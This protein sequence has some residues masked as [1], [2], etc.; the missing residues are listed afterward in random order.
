MRY[1]PGMQ[2]QGP[3]LDYYRR[4]V[5][6]VVQ[7]VRKS[8]G[9]T[10]DQYRP[11]VSRVLGH[12][13]SRAY[14]SHLETGRRQIEAAELLALLDDAGLDAGEALSMALHRMVHGEMA[15]ITAHQHAGR[16]RRAKDRDRDDRIK[17]LIADIQQLDRMQPPRPAD[18]ADHPPIDK[19]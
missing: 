14:L 11:I 7:M 6:L 1:D 9:L 12:P 13:V 16:L 18:V 8:Y 15:H 2:P 19:S 4:E 3:V 17:M 5:G 10:Q